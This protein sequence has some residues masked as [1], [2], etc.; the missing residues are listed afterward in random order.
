[1]RILIVLLFALATHASA[2][3]QRDFTANKPVFASGGGGK[4]MSIDLSPGGRY[5]AAV[6]A[7]QTGVVLDRETGRAVLNLGEG[8][9]EAAFTADGDRVMVSST[10]GVKHLEIPNQPKPKSEPFSFTGRRIL[11]HRSGLQNDQGQMLLWDIE[12]TESYASFRPRKVD[13][14]QTAVS[15]DGRRWAA[16]GRLRDSTVGIELADLPKG[17]ITARGELDGKT[18]F[19]VTFSRNGKQVLVAQREGVLVLESAWGDQVTRLTDASLEEKPKPKRRRSGGASSNIIPSVEQ[20]IDGGSWGPRK[21][22][23]YKSVAAGPNGLVYCGGGDGVLRIWDLA[24][25]LIV[26]RLDASYFGRQLAAIDRLATDATGERLV[27]SAGRDVVFLDF[28]SE[29]KPA[30]PANNDAE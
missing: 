22:S 15:P 18:C 11:G 10:S 29:A 30:A 13:V 14:A 3:E 1:M 4:P 27:L 2:A 6:G 8:V 7:N 5:A 25:G 16:V 24:S 26:A 17:H 28:T 21:P 19:G 9:L 20:G 23:G 12:T